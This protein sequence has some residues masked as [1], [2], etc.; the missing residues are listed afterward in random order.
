MEIRSRIMAA[1]AKRHYDPIIEL[2]D[3][4]TRRNDNG[5]FFYPPDFRKDIHLQLAQFIAPRLKASEITVEGDLSL[6]IEVTHFGN[7]P[8]PRQ[9]GEQVAGAIGRLALTLP[10][11]AGGGSS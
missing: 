7:A 1:M 4:V 11:A 8:G 10:P 5:D 6:S 3:M 9:V 2:I